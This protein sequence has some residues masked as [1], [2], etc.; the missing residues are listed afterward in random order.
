KPRIIAISSHGVTKATHA[1]LPLL[2]LP[3]MATIKAPHA[4]KRGMERLVYHAA[5]ITPE[6]DE[7]DTPG[8]D[9]LPAGWEESAGPKGRWS[10]VVIRA[11][12]LTDGKETGKHRTGPALKGMWTISRRDVAHFIVNDLL[13]NWSTYEGQ[14]ISVG[15]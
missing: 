2:T 10:G 1:T 13:K 14:G 9:I 7:R 4:D 8:P 5:A 11:A 3:I 6:W 12:L 15:Y